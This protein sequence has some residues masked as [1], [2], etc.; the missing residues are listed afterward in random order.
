MD[1]MLGYPTPPQ[2]FP[3]H[4]LGSTPGRPVHR[5]VFLITETCPSPGEG[6]VG[7]WLCIQSSTE[8]LAAELLQPRLGILQIPD[9]LCTPGSLSDSRA[10]WPG[11]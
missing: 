7:G 4:L 1:D 6:T 10:S 8:E 2:Q 9:I 5:S 3:L 11:P